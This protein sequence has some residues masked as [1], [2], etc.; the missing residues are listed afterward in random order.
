M[1]LPPAVRI[2]PM[3]R[4]E[5]GQ[6]KA[7]AVQREY[8]SRDLPEAGGRYRFYERGL[9]A[10]AGTV[11][12]FQYDN[13]VVAS[14]T[15]LD[16]TR[17]RRP[18]EDGC[19]GYFDFDSSTIR[20]FRPMGPEQMR[21]V[22]PSFESFGQVRQD[23]PSA[24]YP[25]F[26]RATL[27]GAT[28]AASILRAVGRVIGGDRKK[29]FTRA[30]VRVAANV[31]RD[32]WTLSWNPIF[33]GMRIDHPGK[34]PVQAKRHRNV[35]KRIAYGEFVVTAYGWTLVRSTP[36][37]EDGRHG[38]DLRK[39]A[40]SLE[41]KGT[42]NPKDQSDERERTLVQI[43]QRRGYTF[44]RRLIA[45][46][47]GRC[48]VTKCDAKPALEAAHILPYAGDKSD[49]ICNGLLLRGDIHTLFDLD[50]IGINP[51]TFAVALARSL[52]GTS[53]DELA[54]KAISMPKDKD[55]RPNLAALKRRWREFRKGR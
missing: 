12:L 24:R 48:A 15:L 33:Q 32:W 54:G 50:L 44:R 13:A 53:Y 37:D 27:D 28:I 36:P 11:V 20:V 14:A 49:F 5:F 55:K 23:L 42:F 16:V 25:T 47:E 31:D 43:A 51:R 7:S 45:A 4:K 6:K 19:S 26:L 18:D 30:D 8:F 10:V 9:G 35:L 39:I 38:T 21:E 34:A 1:N 40:A 2:L 52:R 29:V 3:S 22:W 46:Y 17:F 41:E